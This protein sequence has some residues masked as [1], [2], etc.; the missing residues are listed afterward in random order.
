M[1]CHLCQEIIPDD[2]RFCEHCGASQAAAKTALPESGDPGLLTTPDG[3]LRWTYELNMWKNPTILITLIKGL[4]LAAAVPVLL[5]VVLA[6]VENGVTES[7]NALSVVLPGIFGIMLGLLMIA[8]PLAAI[9]NGGRYC[10][11]FEMDDVGV[12]HTQ[13]DKQFRKNKVVAML[14]VLAGIASGKPQIAG[15]GLLAGSKRSSYSKFAKVKKIV[16]K[17][18]RHVI[19]VNESLNRNQIYADDKIYGLIEKHITS[20][21]PKAKFER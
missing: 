13:M 10:V 15:A 17:P 20:K 7:L 5:V 2:A 8:Y 12:K 11:V 1:Q 14:T 9:L 18:R 21:C 19:Y 16:S 4:S 6:L 3:V